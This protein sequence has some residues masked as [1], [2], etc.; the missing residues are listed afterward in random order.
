VSQPAPIAVPR[1]DLLTRGGEPADSDLLRRHLHGDPDAF[2]TLFRRHKQ[3]LWAVA[4]RLLGDVDRAAEAIQ[5]A[6]V[7]AV[8]NGP[9]FGG[10]DAATT[11]LYRVV[12]NVCVDR[13]RRS[14]PPAG[15]G[16]VT[17]AL[18]RL[19]IEQ[20][21]ALVLIDMLGFSVADASMIL[22]ISVATVLSRSARGRQRLLTELTHAN[23][24]GLSRT[25]QLGRDA[26]IDGGAVACHGVS[27]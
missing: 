25:L 6:M 15:D 9:D 12:V 14:A 4:I 21:S 5:D 20:Q 17:A 10:G 7:L 23:Q 22:G 16:T 11:W 19:V 3:D 13:M 2:S 1:A 24:P 26:A 18:R 27:R 8:R